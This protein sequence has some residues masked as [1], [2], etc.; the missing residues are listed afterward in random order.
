MKQRVKRV[1]A[2]VL[3][4][5]LITGMVG[6]DISVMTV[7]AASNDTV[8][9]MSVSENDVEELNVDETDVESDDVEE[10]TAEQPEGEEP[11]SE[12][13]SAD[14]NGE[15][16]KKDDT[17]VNKETNVESDKTEDDIDSENGES[18]TDKTEEDVEADVPEDTAGNDSTNTEETPETSVSA[19]D[20]SV[21]D[22][23]ILQNE[24]VLDGELELFAD[25]LKQGV[26]FELTAEAGVLTF[27]SLK[28][29]VTAIGGSV[30]IP[31]GVTRIPNDAALFN[32]NDDVTEV[33]FETGSMLEEIDAEAFSG[34]AI[35]KITLPKSLTNIGEKAFQNA[36]L[37]RVTL[38]AGGEPVTIALNAFAYN[39]KLTTFTS[40]GRIATIGKAAFKECVKLNR[41]I[42]LDGV[43]SIE[44]QAF[45]GCTEL[46]YIEL[47]VTVTEIKKSTFEGCTDLG[48][49]TAYDGINAVD[50]GSGVTTIRESAFEG[51]TGL[52]ELSIPANVQT[53]E[54]NAFAGC[55][56][57]KCIEIYNQAN[58]ALEPE[59]ACGIS[60][61]D[62][63][64]PR[65]KGLMIRSYNGTAEDWAGDHSEDGVRFAT[66]YQ[67]H[68]ISYSG[69][70]NGTVKAN[71][72]TAQMG[73]KITLTVTPKEGYSL[74]GLNYEYIDPNTKER[75]NPFID[76]WEC[77]FTMPD[78]PVTITAN[79]VELEEKDY[80]ELIIN[81]DSF[82]DVD[83]P[84]IVVD[85]YS[86]DTNILTF[87]KP[88]QSVRVIV[89]GSQNADP[90]Y[91][92][93]AFSS[94]NTKVVTVN[95]Y[96]VI[97]AVAEGTA[98]ITIKM[99][100]KDSKI[101]PISFKVSVGEPT[102]VTALSLEYVA[103]RADVEYKSMDDT[104][105]KDIGFDIITY[106]AS[107]LK[108]Q[109]RIITVTPN[110]TDAS[111]E[112]LDVI[113]QVASNDTAVAKPKASKITGK[114]DITIPKGALGETVVTFTAVDGSDKPKEE[115]FIVRVIDDIPRLANGDITVDPLST[116]GALIDLVSVYDATP[117]VSDLSIVKKV[118]DK[119]GQT[120]YPDADDTFIIEE[121]N[122]AVYLKVTDAV[123]KEYAV[124]AKKVFKNTY[125]IHGTLEET[126]TVFY[127]PISS[128]TIHKKNIKPSVK[129]T[130][131][132]NT[133]YNG[134]A[135]IADV[136][137]ITVTQNQKDLVVESCSLVGL[138]NTNGVN[139][140]DDATFAENFTVSMDDKQVITIRRT[141]NDESLAC[142][143][144][145]KS[146]GKPVL[147]GMLRIRYEGYTN[148]HDIKITIPTV[149]TAPS[150]ALDTTKV[151]LNSQARMQEFDVHFVNKK[152]KAQ[153][154]DIKDTTVIALD[155]T[156][157]GT[158][159][160]LVDEVSGIAPDVDNDSIHV[161]MKE[162]PKKGKIVLALKQEDWEPEASWNQKK[163]IK[164]T[165]NV[166]VTNSAPTVKLGKSTLTVNT[167]CRNTQDY[168]TMVLN[169]G[170]STLLNGQEFIYTGKTPVN[171]DVTYNE[172]K[173][174]AVITGDVSNG[175]YRFS[176][177][178]KYQYENSTTEWKARKVTVTVKVIDTTPSIK[179][180]NAT[181]T[182]N[183]N[184]SYDGGEQYD[185]AVQTF[186]W[187]NLPAEYS[188]YSLDAMNVEVAWNG[189]GKYYIPEDCVQ[190]RVS[191][192]NSVTV[193]VETDEKF[194]GKNTY[195]VSGL[196][197]V[198][199]EDPSDIIAV[200]DF[201][202][203]VNSIDKVPTVTVNAKGTI[204][205]L[206]PASEVIC[207]TKLTNVNGT[208]EEVIIRELDENG[209]RIEDE[210]LCHF[211]AEHN[212]STGK[213]VI[214]VKSGAQLEKRAYSI[215]LYYKL[216]NAEKGDGWIDG[217]YQVAKDQKITPKQTM[218]KISVDKK[219]ATFF[220]GDKSRTQ[221]V[222]VKKTSTATAAI[223]DIKFS[224]KTS[225]TL[226]NAFDIDYDEITGNM[227]LILKNSAFVQQN[228]E[229]TLTFEIV[230]DGQLIDTT[231]TTFTLKV[232]VV[233]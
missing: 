55:S 29:G 229:H 147:V 232:K 160:G 75:E 110:G 151:T 63:S 67:K 57:L 19:N 54:S 187:Q 20:T 46:D 71:V 216:S 222:E 214:K 92:E 77:S 226:Q 125:Y 42:N 182:V 15:A 62:T 123:E 225:K 153:K 206:D 120:T 94:S 219:A 1:L 161:Q 13:E 11:Q 128:I 218:P 99:T 45:I 191:E 113:Y 53:I 136:G 85:V 186:T 140:A 64:F 215:Q 203:N 134:K 181:F 170:D 58:V 169:Q 107:R 8:A 4:V 124:G 7:N 168:T 228:K 112:K 33:I 175:T 231:G 93:L 96:G 16:D 152:N 17:D 76:S 224:S 158:T 176:C 37:E 148:Y 56:A 74:D 2:T 18:D 221:T 97:R 51:C 233:K 14:K 41:T 138:K 12:D 61:M 200:K 220:A 91:G 27:N 157:K 209:I 198:N 199:N 111:G 43:T 38:V 65:V 205:P 108:N 73:E 164:A 66:L 184:C 189:K 195:I 130:G 6:S 72:S 26:D 177:E 102:Y 34:S 23:D 127:I 156:D 132:I 82:V 87:T 98:T 166:A 21:S 89:R 10:Q 31:A 173:L 105:A 142:Y 196:Q 32:G 90:V 162:Y 172:G 47:P 9:A 149:T 188:N 145:G 227:E 100:D 48:T 5:V 154:V 185:S 197:M 167:S 70:T 24:D 39:T 150:Y 115:Q 36:A 114:T 230:C 28:E 50:F 81:E 210:N 59:N 190:V 109:D 103:S 78:A 212:S 104:E 116:E 129:L 80:A 143:T 25:T 178:P 35:T 40:N 202:I 106:P 84:K 79:F 211:K 60:L 117:D 204:N 133:F 122:G 193:W 118:V 83:E 183:A 141:P 137:Q 52:E 131:K 119:K 207:T 155:T 208:I 88:W 159:S 180:K 135:D 146:K 44:E 194:V 174:S 217:Y 192:D 213:T 139:D 171:L 49:Y 86:V 30:T 144:D 121:N 163:V 165:I 68:T 69:I 201:T 3:M 179:L 223:E 101:K 126:D 95:S 22:N